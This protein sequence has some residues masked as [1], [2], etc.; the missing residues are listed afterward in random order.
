MLFYVKMCVSIA[1]VDS[2]TQDLSLTKAVFNP[3]E[4]QKLTFKLVKVVNVTQDRR[5]LKLVEVVRT[6]V[7]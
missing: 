2:S 7:P 1:L 5:L 3:T 6:T 4:L